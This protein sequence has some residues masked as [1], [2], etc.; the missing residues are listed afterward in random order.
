MPESTDLIAL[1]RSIVQAGGIPAWVDAQLTA[2]SRLVTRRDLKDMSE[3]ELEGYKKDLKAEAEERRTL[4]REA[5]S[6]YRANHIVHLGDGVFWSDAAGPDK[7][8]VPHAEERLAENELPRLDS[9]QQLA[10]ALGQTVAQLRW[11]AYHRDAATRVHY[12]RFVI[13]KR[14]GG[15]RAI[16]A[17]LPRLKAAQHWILRNV[18]EKLPVH[19]AAHG[20][21]AGR[22][23]LSNAAAHTGARAVVKMD[24]KDFFPTVTLQRVKG[25]FRKAGYREQVAT[26]LALICTE[27]PREVVEHDGKTYYVSL[28]PRCLPQGA[29]TSPAL[30]NTL[31][32]RLDCRLSG[33]AK[34]LGY[35]YTRY[36]DDLTFSL[37]VEHKGKPRL[38]TLLG[39]VRQIVEAEGFRLHPDKTRV[40]RRGG[41]QQVTGLVVNGPGTPRA[42]RELRRQ[43][44]AAAHNLGRGKPLPQGESVDRLRGY[45]AYVRMTDPELGASLA[46]ALSSARDRL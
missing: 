10:E 43:L 29:P 40:H 23:T 4:R 28:G 44:R 46:A 19:G 35:H 16:W 13:P 3:R 1:W 11:L 8:D 6:A 20:F 25:V 30:T 38:G 39:S 22:S 2:R 41:R 37:P 21:L 15:E 17:P 27:S 36:A 14:G 24:I 18:A 34:A 9:P 7:W 32:L 26:L 33:L 42:P 12:R 45:A 5:W 31:C